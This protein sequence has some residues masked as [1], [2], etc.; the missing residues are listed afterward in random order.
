MINIHY[1]SLLQDNDAFEE[2]IECE[3]LEEFL[4]LK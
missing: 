1:F 2:A 3:R 4:K